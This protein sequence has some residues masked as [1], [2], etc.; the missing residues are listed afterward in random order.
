MILLH[1]CCAPCGSASVERLLL[2]NREVTLFFS[3]SNIFPEE[4]FQKRL[5][6]AEKLASHYG[7]R[8]VRDNYEHERWLSAVKGLE[9]E[10]EK[11]MRCSACFRFSLEN[12]ARKAY[13]LGIGE[14][15]TTLTISPHKDSKQVFDA[16]KGMEG[17]SEHDFKKRDGFRR[18]LELSKELGL[19]RQEYC[20][21]EFSLNVLTLR[22]SPGV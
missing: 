5:Y 11:G 1:I 7:I 20:G 2:E 8:L 6:Y 21:C 3:N 9:N 19:Y 4:E 17:F 10:P 13:E 16:G 12:T 18:S 22:E 15:T 14:F